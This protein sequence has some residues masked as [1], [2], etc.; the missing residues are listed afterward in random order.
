MPPELPDGRTVTVPGRGEVFLRDVPGPVG[1]PTVLLL[2]GWTS[3][4]DLTWWR[5]YSS[6][7]TI[8]RVLAVDHRG[9]GRG[10]RSD[11]PFTLEAAADDAAGLLRELGCGP[12]I[13]CGY[14]MGGPIAMLLWRRHPE[15]VAGLVFEATA[16]E[17]QA[18]WRERIVWRTMGL[19]E[20]VLR[21]ARS[22][23]VVE[24]L[25]RE[26]LEKEP[27]LLAHRGWLEGELRRGDPAAL[28]E[29]GRA[30]GRYDARP[31]A[32]RVAV[33]TAVVVT[34]E[35]QL[36]R[37]SK[38]RALAKALP[39]AQTFELA[40]DHDACLASV[41]EFAAVTVEA[42][43]AVMA[44]NEEHRSNVVGSSVRRTQHPTKNG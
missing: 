37:P 9:H 40:A 28:A 29:A 27:A 14:S 2:H 17:W 4:A 36:V 43:T 38:Q 32:H 6:L 35:D 7:G 30:L 44:A 1:G 33:P 24:R 8:A 22:K 11:E 39:G 16:L 20:R 19:V 15:L 31:F 25:L 10:I 41:E 5:V 3:T 18:S 26:V 23:G 34:S 21:S 13:V 12:A 42:I